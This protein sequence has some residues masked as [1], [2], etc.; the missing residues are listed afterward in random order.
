MIVDVE[1][2]TENLR[3]YN[4]IFYGNEECL[5]ASTMKRCKAGQGNLSNKCRMLN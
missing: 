2:G 3:H 4:S 5:K 1:E